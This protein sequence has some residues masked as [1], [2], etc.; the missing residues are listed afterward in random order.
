MVIFLLIVAILLIELILRLHYSSKGI[1]QTDLSNYPF[2][3]KVKNSSGRDPYFIERIGLKNTPSIKSYSEGIRDDIANGKKDIV[4]AVGCSCTE[5]IAFKSNET[6]TG[7]LQQM[8]PDKCKVINAGIGGYGP[9]QKYKMMQDLVKYKPKIAIIQ[10]LDFMRV[11]IDEKKMREGRRHFLFYQKLKKTSFLLYYLSKLKS[12]KFIGPRAPYMNRKLP[13]E[14]LWELNIKYLDSMQK[15]CKD[16]QV[17]LVFFVWPTTNPELLHNAYFHEKVKEYCKSNKIYYFDARN[18]Y[19]HYREEELKIP[20]DAHP[21]ALANKLVAK[22][23][24]EE[25][26]KEKLV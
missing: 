15:V 23:A 12:Q 10:L 4:L 6:Y 7:F 3:K 17:K 2:F 20:Y 9:F 16:N 8:L 1:I 26:R 13:K 25:L 14:K 5:G 11:P 22:A 18:I 24:Y 21:S 19:K